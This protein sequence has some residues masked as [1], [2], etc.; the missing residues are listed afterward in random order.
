[1]TESNEELKIKT[2]KCYTRI[3]STLDPRGHVVDT[4]FEREIITPKELKEISDG[5]D[6]ETR[7]GCFLS[8]LF[9]TSHPQAFV[10]FREAF[11]KDYGW[12]VEFIDKSQ[13]GMS[14]CSI[15]NTCSYLVQ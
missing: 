11:K 2:R 8:H 12:M 4:L 10:V 14:N 9:Q 3:K 13:Q 7:A 5:P 6:A 1:M 15:L